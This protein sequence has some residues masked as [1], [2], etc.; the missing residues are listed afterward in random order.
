MDERERRIRTEQRK[1]YVLLLAIIVITVAAKPVIFSA[2]PYWTIQPGFYFQ[3]TDTGGP[4]QFSANVRV[5]EWYWSGG[6]VMFDE[7]RFVGSPTWARLGF[8]CSSNANMT[9][10][11]ASS[12]R[13]EYIVNANASLQST[14]Q[15]YLYER[16]EPNSVTGADSWNYNTI[17]KIL[18]TKVVHSSPA[19]IIIAWGGAPYTPPAPAPP[20]GNLL[21]QY[22]RIGDVSGFAIAIYTQSMGDIFFGLILLALT[23]PLY[24]R[25]QSLGYISILWITV[26]SLIETLVPTPGINLG[27]IILVIGVAGVLYSLFTRR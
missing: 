1:R 10:Q 23:I 14:T 27:K 8:R 18:T 4:I 13:I 5:E 24:I 12:T 7:F 26:S 16:G 15:I 25:T 2:N 22:L 19:T 3:A 6:F 17:S 20:G 11:T 21:Q 9:V